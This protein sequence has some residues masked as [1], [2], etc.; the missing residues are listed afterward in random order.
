MV[1]LGMAQGQDGGSGVFYSGRWVSA[2]RLNRLPQAAAVPEKR[3]QAV[4]FWMAIRV[5]PSR[6]MR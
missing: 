6:Y 1:D 2:C 3:A 4:P 5:R